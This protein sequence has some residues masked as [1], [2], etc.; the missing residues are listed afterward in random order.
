MIYVQE[1]LCPQNH[2]GPNIA[3]CPVDATT[4]KGYGTPEVD[5]ESA[6]AAVPSMFSVGRD[7]G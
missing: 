2:P 6:S 5:T 7:E 1:A 4:Q 3:E